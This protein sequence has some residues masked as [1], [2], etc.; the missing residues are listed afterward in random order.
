MTVGIKN[1]HHFHG[2][3]FQA[4]WPAGSLNPLVRHVP[5]SETPG[6]CS[7]L[8]PTAFS[9]ILP[10]VNQMVADTGVAPA[11]VGYRVGFIEGSFILAS[12]CTGE[13]FPA[14]TTCTRLTHNHS[15]AVGSTVRSH[16]AQAMH[17]ALSTR[18]LG[19]RMTADVQAGVRFSACLE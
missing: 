8:R 16:R 19:R 3:P 12:F 7:S 10:F 14:A 18:C 5:C 4:C 1:P 15:P 6:A 11:D 9:S 2:D 17:C 13:L